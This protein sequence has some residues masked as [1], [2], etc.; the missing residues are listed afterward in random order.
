MPDIK[1]S[2][3]Y[4]DSNVCVGKRGYIEAGALWRSEDIIKVINDAGISGALVY[5]GW[6]R[7]YTPIYGNERLIG[8]LEKA[9]DLFYGIY[10]VMPGFLG[11][12]SSPEEVISDIKGKKMAASVMFPKS[13]TY[14]PTETVM[15]EYYSALE[16][17]GILL[18]VEES[19]ITS[20]DLNAL[21]TLHPALNVLLVRASWEN[22]E[23]AYAL[24][25]KHS[26]LYFDTSM[27]ENKEV[28]E[29]AVK[30]IGSERL[31][32]SS[33]IPFTSPE[34]IIGIVEGSD[35][36]REE[37]QLIASGN[38]IRLCKNAL[39]ISL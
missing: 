28:L 35:I 34:K 18:I 29:C 20:S 37:K 38:L 4:L 15:G 9:E 19:E 5:A 33:G 23:N 16:K 11:C 14:I 32:F 27:M 10:A 22:C 17:A 12:A 1:T 8:E 26:N 3:K 36:S 6:A 13:Q 21:L 31:V 30:N 39:D 25:K 7:N 2:V 24:A